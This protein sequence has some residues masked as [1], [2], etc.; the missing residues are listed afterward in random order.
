MDVEKDGFPVTCLREL[1]I[2]KSM[3]HPNIV[4]LKEVVTGSSL[5]R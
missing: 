3:E 1:K 5:D 2:L 4:K